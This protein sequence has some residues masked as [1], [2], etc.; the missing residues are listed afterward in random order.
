MSLNYQQQN[1]L[2]G[3]WVICYKV[4]VFPE[5]HREN[6]IEIFDK[7]NRPKENLKSSYGNQPSSS[8]LLYEVSES[9]KLYLAVLCLYKPTAISTELSDFTLFGHV[10]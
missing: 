2:F 9:R 5:V 8:T 7:F 1:I 4:N 3:E 10:G 6:E